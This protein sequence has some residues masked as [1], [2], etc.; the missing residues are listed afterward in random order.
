M[1]DQ[2]TGV[3]ANKVRHMTEAN[4]L[5]NP[6][7][8]EPPAEQHKGIT[9]ILG[10][11]VH[12]ALYTA[13]QEPV[14]GVTQIVDE[15]A[16]TKFLPK[17]QF[18]DA[19][20]QAKFGTADW[21]AQQVGSA[22]GMLLPF[23]V[24]GKGVRGVLGTSA[25][26]ASL[27]SRKAAFGMSMKEAG[28]TGF[29]YDALLKPSDTNH[30]GGVGGFL[31]DRGTQGA[32]GAGTFMT[33]TGSSIG[34]R[35][36]GGAAV[37]KSAFLPLLKNPIVNGVLS[38]VPAGLFTAEAHSLAK[39][40][41]LASG[42]EVGQSVYGM[43]LI[44]GGFGAMHSFTAPREN[45]A[46]S[47]Y[48]AMKSAIQDGLKTPE[49]N[50][51]LGLSLRGGDGE[52]SVSPPP[53]PD[54]VDPAKVEQAKVDP[55]ATPDATPEIANP[56]GE[57]VP[58]ATDLSSGELSAGLEALAA[59]WGARLEPEGGKGKGKGSKGKGSKVVEPTEG[60]AV[61]PPP[62]ETGAAPTI[63]MLPKGDKPPVIVNA[64]LRD[65]TADSAIPPESRTESSDAT[66][67][68]GKRRIT[69]PEV[70]TARHAD[71]IEGAKQLNSV[72]KLED[73]SKA[74]E[75]R[76]IMA[77][78]RA[79]DPLASTTL[80]DAAKQAREEAV[81]AKKD[82]EEQRQKFTEYVETNGQGL[83]KHLET[84]AE[85][86]KYPEKALELVKHDFAV[87][88]GRDL[89]TTASADGATY[90]QQAAFDQFVRERGQS[91]RPELD[92][93]AEEQKNSDVAR[94]LVDRAFEPRQINVQ[95]EDVGQQ[96]AMNVGARILTADGGI[97]T[98]ALKKFAD[99]YGPA[100]EKHMLTAADQLGFGVDAKIKIGEAYHGEAFRQGVEL[101]QR[102]PLD[103][104]AF[105]QFAENDGKALEKQMWQTAI[106]LGLDSTTQL[107]V[108]EA[109]RGVQSW[110]PID[111]A[112]GDPIY[113]Q[114]VDSAGKLEFDAEGKPVYETTKDGQPIREAVAVDP[115]KEEQFRKVVQILEIVSKDPNSPPSYMEVVRQALKSPDSEGL[116][117]ALDWY[118]TRSGNE[119]LQA[120]LREGNFPT[121]NWEV[122]GKPGT[123][124]MAD[125]F[126]ATTEGNAAKARVQDFSDILESLK[127][128]SPEELAEKRYDV[129]DWLRRN[130]EL[131]DAA[132]RI[133][134][135][136]N[137]SRVAGV[138]DTYFGTENL[139]SFIAA[140]DKYEKVAAEITPEMVARMQ[141]P[142][143]DL[144]WE[145]APKPPETPRMWGGNEN[146]SESK[147]ALRTRQLEDGSVV[148]EF[149]PDRNPD[150]VAK[151]TDEPSGQRTVEYA[152]GSRFIQRPDGIDIDQMPDGSWKASF[153]N[154]N[155]LIEYAQSA[156]TDIDK[157]VYENGKATTLY[158][159]GKIEHAGVEN[160]TAWKNIDGTVAEPKPA[161]VA[162][163][164]DGPLGP[165][166]RSR[167]EVADLVSKLGSSDYS[168]AR[169]AAINL[170]NSFGQMTD[171][172]FVQWLN[173]ALGTHP[174]TFS[175]SG[176]Q[177]PNLVDLHLL[178][179]GQVLLEN[180][181][182][183]M[184][185]GGDTLAEQQSPEGQARAFE[186]RNIIRQFLDAPEGRPN[187]LQYPAWLVKENMLPPESWP[188]NVR[189]DVRVRFTPDKLPPEVAD[190]LANNPEKAPKPKV[191]IGA[192]G[193]PKPARPPREFTL[194]SDTLPSRLRT[195]SDVLQFAP[196][197]IQAKLLSL[198]AADARAVNDIMQVVK[199]PKEMR[200]RQPA[201]FTEL[202]QLTVPQAR[203]IYTVKLLI[204]AIRDAN[205]AQQKN[206]SAY[207]ANHDI[208]TKAALQLMPDSPAAQARVL[209]LVN[210]LSSGDIR[211]PFLPKGE[212]LPEVTKPT[213]GGHNG[214]IE[215][216][217]GLRPGEEAPLDDPRGE[218]Y[219]MDEA[220][221]DEFP[222]PVNDG[223]GGANL[224]P[225]EFTL[226]DWTGTRESDPAFDGFENAN[227][228][229]N[230][231][232]TG[233][234]DP[235]DEH[236][237]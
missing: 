41:H 54:G 20:V 116:S 58:P 40:G 68:A 158:R 218:V 61:E 174:D 99:D 120:L 191:E 154:G 143:A 80:T 217:A 163:K 231:L 186:G 149:N 17:V 181:V 212:S 177:L 127:T 73:A 15:F 50:A 118:A 147:H 98:A 113:R 104:D 125:L 153:P 105:K 155:Y 124:P 190:Y 152:D 183:R 30:T 178:Q 199:P 214:K 138:L 168:E 151:V 141:Q 223:A 234:V 187:T 148:A 108:F 171:T 159:D 146:I 62:V 49:A 51:K 157:I 121:E 114:K 24:V 136:T 10:D 202:L 97:D 91:V 14:S 60:D 189:K 166:V 13:V 37:E 179:G 94:A 36:L 133:G 215:R 193:Q 88:E 201:E 82:Y 225:S 75:D 111:D 228:A 59:K 87:K 3:S 227:E 5:R 39:T 63:D 93:I 112:N 46:P 173:F 130:P 206:P 25:E 145:L 31:L 209:E 100:M 142:G 172:Q 72:L 83:Q 43:S 38:G 45:G 66:A 8:P 86:L 161:E 92:R 213:V 198:G 197:D 107:Q 19:P 204:Q 96:A 21:H 101:L 207:E 81:Q 232:D 195:M 32:I 22:V 1:I 222:D 180:N 203:D 167:A 194:P 85:Q 71:L 55:P 235:T 184:L 137:S 140:K 169:T 74:A 131:H 170:K 117:E 27:M 102:T 77:E 11:A 53:K 132:R 205:W 67:A 70:D 175:G 95:V 35:S 48:D 237:L 109:Y 44:G 78:T 56:T 135:N 4:E 57:T 23:M 64:E 216:E 182:Q 90:E 84:V 65:A 219:P 230:A 233:M 210:G 176:R 7:K 211:V 79:R 192:D 134:E 119:R 229:N 139:K 208:A 224:P 103:V 185:R 221:V 33:L 144:F 76:A 236:G 6:N 115:A 188:Q 18:L 165:N 129:M 150:R 106:D 26:E 89:L 47:R 29:A 16:G 164:P 69:I 128:A 28:L 196:K 200:D 110:V 42:E 9:D 220:P 34:L 156:K 123:I 122:S 160:Q 226:D 126:P 12:S 52:E 2:A 162:D